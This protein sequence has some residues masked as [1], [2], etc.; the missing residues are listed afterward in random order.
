MSDIIDQMFEDSLQ[1]EYEKCGCAVDALG[2]TVNI[3]KKHQSQPDTRGS[4]DG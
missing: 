1:V 3:C 4:I 2:F